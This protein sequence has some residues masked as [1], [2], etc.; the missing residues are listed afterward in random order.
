MCAHEGHLIEDGDGA[1]AVQKEQQRGVHVMEQVSGLMAL[2]AQREA[3][4][5]GPADERTNVVKYFQTRW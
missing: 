2:G 4:L 5:C 3:D 1:Q